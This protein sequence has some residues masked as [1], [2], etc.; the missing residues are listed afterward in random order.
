MICHEHLSV[1]DEYN[2]PHVPEMDFRAFVRDESGVL[3]PLTKFGRKA[4]TGRMNRARS[5]SKLVGAD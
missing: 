5:Q 3:A 2:N 1:W 4:M